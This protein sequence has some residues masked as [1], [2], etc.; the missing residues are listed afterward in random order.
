VY[1]FPTIYRR[2]IPRDMVKKKTK[3]VN[4]VET[5]EILEF[6]YG[7]RQKPGQVGGWK[8]DPRPTL[9]V[10]YDDKRKYIEG[11]NTNYLSRYYII[12]LK[13]IMAKF[14]G[15][16]KDGKLFYKVIKVTAPYALKKGYRKYMRKS[17]HHTFL[18]VYKEF[19]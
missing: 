11:L 2:P 18:H 10:F 8:N 6:I 1:K 4:E 14:P 7:I 3:L 13:Y 19:K 16:R 9:L 12:K 17:L 15:M 5:G